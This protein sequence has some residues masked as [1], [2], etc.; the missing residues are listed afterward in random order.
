MIMDDDHKMNVMTGQRRRQNGA[1]F[2]VVAAKI[3]HKY[4]RKLHSLCMAS[5]Q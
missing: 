5:R 3:D 2:V 4:N 1:F